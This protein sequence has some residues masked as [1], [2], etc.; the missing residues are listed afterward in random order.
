[1]VREGS[2]LP[3]MPH[4]CAAAGG[5]KLEEHLHNEDVAVF[6]PL[7]DLSALTGSWQ[8]IRLAASAVARAQLKHDLPPAWAKLRHSDL[9]DEAGHSIETLP[10]SVRHHMSFTNISIRDPFFDAKV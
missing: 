1:M 10:E 5:R 3:K 7:Q 4:N 6:V 8:H 2:L 9:E